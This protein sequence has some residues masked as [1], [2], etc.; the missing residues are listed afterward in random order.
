MAQGQPES[1]TLPNLEA[2]FSPGFTLG[3]AFLAFRAG[4]AKG[5]SF[6]LA[7]KKE[8]GFVLFGRARGVE[9]YVARSGVGT[10]Q[11]F[12]HE[13]VLHFLAADIGKHLPV[14]F[15]TWRKR[16]ATLLLHFP[17]KCWVLDDVL[18]LVWQ[19]ILG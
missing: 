16:L 19:S 14:N 2:P 5:K 18:F 4:G 1:Q 12:A 7:S 10:Y 15:Y 11:I 17:P 8:V 9:R 6:G 13:V 3:C